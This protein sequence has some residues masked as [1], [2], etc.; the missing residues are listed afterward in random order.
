MQ[1]IIIVELDIKKKKLKK[2]IIEI[3]DIFEV[4]VKTLLLPDRRFKRCHTFL[5]FLFKPEKSIFRAY[6]TGLRT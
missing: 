3:T 1:R 4:S 6:F 5:K 2:N